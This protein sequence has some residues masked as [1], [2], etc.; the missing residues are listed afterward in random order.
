MNEFEVLIPMK[1]AA[2]AVIA[3]LA[4]AA[5][6]AAETKPL[7]TQIPEGGVIV[8]GV[9][10]QPAVE[11]PRCGSPTARMNPGS[12]D[13]GMVVYACRALKAQLRLDIDRNAKL[14]ADEYIANNVKGMRGEGMVPQIR[15]AKRYAT[16]G[17]V[18]RDMRSILVTLKDGKTTFGLFIDDSKTGKFI[19]QIQ[20]P[21]GETALV[22]QLA[23]AFLANTR[24]DAAANQKVPLSDGV[25]TALNKIRSDMEVFEVL[26]STYAWRLNAAK[27]LKPD[28]RKGPFSAGSI[29]REGAGIEGQA[30]RF[31]TRIGAFEA[32][33]EQWK[34]TPLWKQAERIA[35]AAL[36]GSPENGAAFGKLTAQ[37]KAGAPDAS[38]L[39]LYFVA[40]DRAAYHRSRQAGFTAMRTEL[41]PPPEEEVI[42]VTA[43]PASS[44]PTKSEA[45]AAV[46]TPQPSSA[47]PAPAPK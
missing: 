33:M 37:V 30:Y 9:A 29:L 6:V 24:F 38:A 27:V 14:D 1:V 13:V 47:A 10:M 7:L 41:F 43:V 42:P 20:V 12:A 45:P 22:D 39:A 23:T 28:D 46:T 16:L 36:K 31:P 8:S 2:L 3:A 44:L 18:P 26:Q 40:R 21:G 15:L 32:A 4:I 19:M 5:P 34:G 35:G 11:L 17:G 25:A